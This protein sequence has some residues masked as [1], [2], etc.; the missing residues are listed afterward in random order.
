[1]TSPTV[2]MKAQISSK[3]GTCLTV[4]PCFSSIPNLM[5][6]S[7][8]QP[9]FV[10][11]QVGRKHTPS[12]MPSLVIQPNYYRSIQPISSTTAW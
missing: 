1:M 12:P 11:D 8:A 5:F 6:L 3:I 4:S 10:S 2:N 9:K 7:S